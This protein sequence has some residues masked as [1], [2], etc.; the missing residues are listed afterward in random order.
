[1]ISVYEIS[2]FILAYLLH[3]FGLH[4]TIHDVRCILPQT[5][6]SM[7]HYCHQK[8]PVSDSVV[9]YSTS[10]SMQHILK[11]LYGQL[12]SGLLNKHVMLP[13]LLNVHNAHELKD[14]TNSIKK[15]S[16]NRCNKCGSLLTLIT[17]NCVRKA[18]YK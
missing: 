8:N 1:M 9:R 15:K 11:T 10:T 4:S 12:S 13:V 16:Q 18:I 17:N 6:V 5:C 2:F 7:Q 14:H 3:L